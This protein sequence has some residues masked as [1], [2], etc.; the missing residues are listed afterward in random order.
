MDH[1]FGFIAKLFKAIKQVDKPQTYALMEIDVVTKCVVSAKDKPF[2][3]TFQVV[4]QGSF[5]SKD[6]FVKMVDDKTQYELFYNFSTLGMGAEELKKYGGTDHAEYAF[7]TLEE[8]KKVKETTVQY[9]KFLIQ[10]HQLQSLEK[11]S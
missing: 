9:I 4:H 8:A 6:I 1:M 5:F 2:R 7:R 3:V 11:I 10:E